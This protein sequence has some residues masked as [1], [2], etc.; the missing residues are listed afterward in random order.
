MKNTQKGFFITIFILSIAILLAGFAYIYKSTNI[1]VPVIVEDTSDHQPDQSVTVPDIKVPITK[2]GVSSID[3]CA[4]ISKPGDY[5]ISKDLINTKSE[6][7][8]NIVDTSNVNL[9]CQNHTISSKNENYNIYVNRSSNFKIS[10]CK[11]ISTL[12]VPVG[13]STQN[14]LSVESSNHGEI[15]D[16]VING[17][18]T[19]VNRSSF[20]TMRNNTYTN[21]LLVYR[22][23]NVMIRDSNFSSLST[24]SV[25]L[26]EGN[27]NSVV[28]NFMDGQSDGIYRGMDGNIGGD[29]GVLLQD[30]TGD[31]IQG[32]TIKNFYDCSIENTGYMYDTKILENTADNAGVCFL[33]GWYH[34][35]VK[36]LIAKDNVA[37][38]M[39][40]LFNFHRKYKLR[41]GEQIVY[42]LNN[43]FENNKLSN[44]RLNTVFPFSSFFFFDGSE[45][46]LSKH[47][48]GNIVLKNNDFTKLLPPISIAPTGMI[49]DGGGNI[50]SGS[51]EN[52]KG[53]SDNI[54]VNCK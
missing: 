38:N 6:P 19:T 33:G 5:L 20:I 21:Q 53:G 49:V 32:N 44:P 50:C 15:S 35:S 46:P 12:N 17:N 34:S 41:P 45:V 26:Q 13:V 24:E 36:N 37:S 14:V 31:L 52:E 47:V 27:N 22:S 3:S 25:K 4:T 54:P 8:I 16:S 18:F 51:S 40:S 9:D 29:D 28:S 42:F 23:N 43:T 2:S 1:Q 39:P 48:V 10:N 11:L 30:E 7:C